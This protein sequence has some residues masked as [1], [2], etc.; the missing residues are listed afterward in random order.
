[1]NQ[2]AHDSTNKNAGFAAI[3]SQKDMKTGKLLTIAYASRSISPT[4]RNWGQCELEARSLRFG[5]DKWRHYFMGI[6]IVYCVVDCKALISLWNNHW[7]DGFML[8]DYGI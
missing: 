6:D 4:E 5:I 2:N 8:T 3:L 1:M 7:R